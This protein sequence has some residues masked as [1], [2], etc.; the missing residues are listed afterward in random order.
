M[1]TWLIHSTKSRPNTNYR[2]LVGATIAA[3]NRVP[4]T[5]GHVDNGK[6]RA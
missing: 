1:R 3:E 6:G 2:K 5:A 4:R